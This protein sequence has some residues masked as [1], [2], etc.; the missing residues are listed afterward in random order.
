MTIFGESAGGWSVSLHIIS[1]V[2]RHLFKNAILNSGAYVYKFTEDRPE[3]HI[4]KWL[5]GVQM[6]G[7]SDDQN[8]G[9]FSTKIMKCLMNAE[10]SKLILITDFWEIIPGTVKVF[11]HVV[12]DGKFL[13]EDPGVMLKKGDFKQN[14]NIMISTVEDEGDFLINNFN[15]TEK[16]HSIHPK[17]LSYSEAYNHL[18]EM[19]SGLNSALPINGEDVA[20][21]YYTGLSDRNGFDLLRKTIGIA[22]GDYFLTCPTLLFAK[23]IYRKS[24]FRSNVYEY[25]FNSKFEDNFFCSHWMGVC[26][27][28]DIFPMFG[29][30]FL[31]PQDYNDR[32]R[33]ISEQ[34][35]EFLTD[36][37]KTGYE[38]N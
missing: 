27:T 5:K 13:P 14:V 4:Q 30:P 37:V 1:P 32:E 29:I 34:M 19:S 26:H 35:I 8:P 18:K 10:I 31:Q 20:K 33:E 17:N 3:D 25:Y 21:L 6:I 22:T 16:F 24:N 36:F 2:S 38:L 7:C 12:I 15:D 23:E 11:D 28:N 9:K